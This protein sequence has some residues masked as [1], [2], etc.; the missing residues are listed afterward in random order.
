ML[1]AG[2][3]CMLS[4]VL[5]CT[6]AMACPELAVAEEKERF[7]RPSRLPALNNRPISSSFF[8]PYVDKQPDQIRLPASL[9]VSPEDTLLNYY[10]ILRE[11]AHFSE[12]TGGCGTVG[13]AE[14]PYPIAYR[15][16]T[17]AYRKRLTY[18]A[19]LEKH[20]DIAHTSLLKLKPV[21][22]D[23]VDGSLRY[24]VELETILGTKKGVTPFAY[25]YGFVY[26]KRVGNRYLIDD[27][28]LTGEDFLCAPYHGWDWK[29][30]HV[31]RIKYGDWCKL[32]GTMHPTRRTGYVK[33]I[34][35]LGTDGETYRFEFV[36]LTNQMDV[37]VGQYR[38]APDGSWKPVT[39]NPETCLEGG[40]G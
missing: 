28:Q 1:R 3:T 12:G 10:S 4:L 29:A 19:Y 14:L 38:R 2:I 22:N 33:Q 36:Q 18:K 15:F 40:N 6:G 32:V 9:T 31:I 24:F 39:I 8:D 5:F 23:R 13:M 27:I 16:L 17:P 35:V 20:A 34:D 7:F 21:R 11:A 25:S 30:E 37:E 26:V